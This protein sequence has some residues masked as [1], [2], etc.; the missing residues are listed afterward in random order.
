[1]GLIYLDACLVIYLAEEVPHWS[2]RATRA[3]TTTRGVRF[4]ISPLVKME[5]LVGCV[6]RADPILE[7][8]YATLFGSFGLVSMP[9][10]VFLD[11]AHLRAVS[12]LKTPDALHVACAQHHRCDALWTNDGRLA[13]ASHG[14]ACKVPVR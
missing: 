13:G 2:R 11:A 5:C 10:S 9:E 7:E 8:K 1:M 3:V 14:L 6:Q 4:V 12:R